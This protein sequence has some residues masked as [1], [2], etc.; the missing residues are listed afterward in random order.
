MNIK[1]IGIDIAKNVFQVNGMEACGSA[2]YWGRKFKGWGHEV[3]LMNPYYVKPYMKAN[4]NDANDAEGICEAVTRTSMRSVPI[5]SV[6]TRHSM[7]ASYSFTLSTGTY[8][9]SEA[10]SRLTGRIWHCY[11]SR[12]K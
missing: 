7:L 5:K 4:K 11:G 12:D 8:S 9:L 1:T 3:K 10:D 6:E 2:H